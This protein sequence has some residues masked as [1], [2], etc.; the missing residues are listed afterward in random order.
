MTNWP[1][2][3]CGRPREQNPSYQVLRLTMTLSHNLQG[4][5]PEPGPLSSDPPHPPPTT[6]TVDTTPSSPSTTAGLGAVIDAIFL[7]ESTKSQV[8][9]VDQGL[10]TE[11]IHLGASI[12]HKTKSKIWAGE[13]L[14]FRLLLSSR[15]DPYQLTVSSG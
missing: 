10:V 13:F 11:D 15:E 14:D 2:P 6:Q 4:A 3:F 7:G 12:S 9:K 5:T 1:R 8:H